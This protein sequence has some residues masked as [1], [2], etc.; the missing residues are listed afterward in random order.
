VDGIFAAMEWLGL[1]WDEGPYYQ[2]QRFER[3]REVIDKWLSKGG[4]TGATVRLKRCRSSA[5][6][7]MAAG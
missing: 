4:P 3:Y 2:T 7:A 5:S 6:L 1:D